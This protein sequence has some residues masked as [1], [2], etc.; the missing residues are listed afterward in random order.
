MLNIR[1]TDESK[2]IEMLISRYFLTCV[3][4]TKGAAGSTL[5]TKD[6]VSFCESQDVSVVDTVGAGDSF[7]AA[8]VMGFLENKPLKELHQRASKIADYVCTQPG[9]TPLLDS[10]L[11]SF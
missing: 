7:T 3:M 4:L 11:V 6:E 10:D 9:A 2:I 5:Y 1:E 8:A